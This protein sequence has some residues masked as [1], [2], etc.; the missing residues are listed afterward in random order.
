MSTPDYGCIIYAHASSTTL[1]PL[2][3]INCSATYTDSH[4]THCCERYEKAWCPSLTSGRHPHTWV[5]I[6]KPCYTFSV[7]VRVNS[8]PCD[9]SGSKLSEVVQMSLATAMLPSSSWKILRRSLARC[10][11]KSHQWVMGLPRGLR[12]C[13]KKLQKGG[14]QEA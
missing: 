10:D 13:L 11:M 7:E 8:H 9:Y 5:F 12:T 1:T 3:A 14:A 6:C 2:G 4:L